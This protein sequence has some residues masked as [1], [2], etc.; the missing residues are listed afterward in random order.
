MFCI[1]IDM[2]EFYVILEDNFFVNMD[3]I[4]DEVWLLGLCNFWWYSFDCL[5][6]DFWIGDV[7]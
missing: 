3:F 1:D 7:G 4:F 2:D 5:M 6:G